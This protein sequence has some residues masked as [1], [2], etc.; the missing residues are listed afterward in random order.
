MI[1]RIVVVFVELNKNK[2]EEVVWFLEIPRVE[3]IDAKEPP[4]PQ[5]CIRRNHHMRYKDVQVGKTPGL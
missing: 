4:D 1:C 2:W 3:E 5:I